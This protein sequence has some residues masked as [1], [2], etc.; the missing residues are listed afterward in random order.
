MK[1][2]ILN[3]L[4]LERCESA[5]GLIDIYTSLEHA[6]N[7]KEVLDSEEDDP[8]LTYYISEYTLK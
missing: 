8:S 4:Y 7:A 2:Y 5:E 1:V 3:W 6:E